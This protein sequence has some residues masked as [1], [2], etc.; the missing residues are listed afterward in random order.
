MQGFEKKSN[1]DSSQININID[2][3]NKKKK[4]KNNFLKIIIVL[5]LLV[6]LSIGIRLI[7]NHF[8][9]KK[10]NSFMIDYPFIFS[11]TDS[12]NSITEDFRV[13]NKFKF[14]NKEYKVKWTSNNRIVKFDEEN[15]KINNSSKKNEKVEIKA[16]YSILG[17][18]I[19]KAS[20]TF[21]ITVLTKNNISK[22]NVNVVSL[23]SVK[24]K[25]YKRNMKVTL[26][27]KGDIA[28]MY[29]DFKQS[30]YT[31]DDCYTV[32]TAYKNNLNINSKCDF[33]LYDIVYGNDVIT[34]IYYLTLN[35]Y[36]IED[37]KIY[38]SVN[39]N[40]NYAIQS[41]KC[42]FDKDI[43]RYPIAKPKK[44]T[45]IFDLLSKTYKRNKDNTFFIFKDYSY[46]TINDN[47]YLIGDYLLIY[48]NDEIHE[49]Y[50]DIINGKI[51]KEV[52]SSKDIMKSC[53][54]K[55]VMNDIKKFEANYV[56]NLE[57]LN[58]LGIQDR[59][60]Y[61]N[62][63]DKNIKTFS[64][65][66][67]YAICRFTSQNMEWYS[68]YMNS[69]NTFIQI[70]AIGGTLVNYLYYEE[71][72]LTST[73][74]TSYCIESD[75]NEFNNS[76]IAVDAYYNIRKAYDYYKKHFNL[77]SYDNNGAG[78][79]VFVDNRIQKDNA[80]WRNDLKVFFINPVETFKYSFAKDCEVIG[81]EYTHAVFSSYSE[82]SSIE[83]SGLNEAYADI[84]GIF[85]KGYDNWKIGEN[86]ING[87]KCYIRDLT[88]INSEESIFTAIYRKP[89]PIKYHDEMWELYNGEEHAIACMIGHIAYQMYSSGKFTT[90]ELENIW[91][92]SLTYGYNSDDTYKTCR[93]H[94][95]QAM[96]DL[97]GKTFNGHKFSFSAEQRDLVRSFFDE[98][99]IE[100]ETDTYECK[101]DT[102]DG[103]L[104]KDDSDLHRFAVMLSPIG[105][106]FNKSPIYVYEECKSPSKDE[107]K[108]IQKRLNEIWASKEIEDLSEYFGKREGDAIIYKQI[109]SWQMNFCEWWIGKNIMNVDSIIDKTLSDASISESS[110][111]NWI[112]VL[113]KFIFVG[114]VDETTR[115]RFYQD[116]LDNI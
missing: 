83:L 86:E 82:G 110:D 18:L 24:N 20:R 96:N 39:N 37:K 63:T 111:S 15:A 5:I 14:N 72:L 36:N 108:N 46:K 66:S 78:I 76:P 115:Y 8:A 104:M 30:I 54:G 99:A 81:H 93:Q 101:A 44:D 27:S 17:G 113:K 38:I 75:T 60:Y 31:A 51:I 87:K 58:Q 13:K 32:L 22:E 109:P 64:T 112:T 47:V 97:N 88:N 23:D 106:I 61:L 84:F 4:K 41:I 45:E 53:T 65:V 90:D 34:Y 62:D 56:D 49:I 92:K 12:Y 10:L 71:D 26:T 102:I 57:F 98:A 55:G 11:N 77:I 43:S 59:K 105:F 100:D 114:V 6:I 94:I 35:E 103:D 25:S 1:N 52:D 2:K 40:D 74:L 79:S 68:Q 21:N 7:G 116:L 89:A 80:C 70:G 33:N 107:M 69:E 95:L 28:A 29:G 19:G 3:Q 67:P 85:I 9:E 16:T 73:Y 50:V 91:Y 42:N 48:D